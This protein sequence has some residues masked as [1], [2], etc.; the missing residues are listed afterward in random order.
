LVRSLRDAGLAA[1][2][3]F[4]ER[5]LKAQLKMADRAG[6]VYAAIVG[7]REVEAGVVTLRRL[8]DGEQEEVALA[9][10]VNWLARQSG[11]SGR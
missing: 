8:S 10:V 1:D 11:A 7:D 3:A 6:A 4:E 5:P 2:A 9:D